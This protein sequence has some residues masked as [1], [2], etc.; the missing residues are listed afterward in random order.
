MAMA[1]H[2][3]EI[4]PDIPMMLRFLNTQGFGQGTFDEDMGYG[5]HAWLQAVFGRLAPKP[6][7]LLADDR[8]PPRILGYSAA[9]AA[10]LRQSLQ[11]FADPLVGAVICDP[12]N[13]LRS[14][15]MPKW[16]VGRCLA[17]EVKVC[18]TGRKARGGPEKD[19]FLIR[20]ENQPNNPL[21]R[22]TIYSRWVQ[23]RVEQ[24]QAAR[25]ATIH[26]DAFRLIQQFRQNQAVIAGER[27]RQRRHLIRP[28][29][30]LRG[31][32]IV[33]DPELFT[34]LLAHGIGRHRAFG[35]GMLLLR[36]PS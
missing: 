1:L 34:D 20:L 13:D 31:E 12:E 5:I 27:E 26:L 6:W 2:M 28:Q 10:T 9:D 32:L 3:I 17:F 35:Y 8:R 19:V 30:V 36:P 11:E 15:P 29:A 4:C 23:E 33:Q 24:H 21:S 14:R 16:R 18:P 25:V 7:R 22:H